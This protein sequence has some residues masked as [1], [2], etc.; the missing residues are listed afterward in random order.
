MRFDVPADD[1]STITGWVTP[2]NPAAEP[3]VIAMLDDGR[4]HRIAASQVWP[5]LRAYGLHA[6]GLCGFVVDAASCPGLRDW[7]GVALFDEH[8][9]T[10]IYRRPTELVSAARLFHLET[11][12][13]AVVA[14]ALG[15]RFQLAYGS[16]EFIGEE[17][18]VGILDIAFT[19]SV[20]VSGALRYRRFERQLRAAGFQCSILLGDPLRTLAATLLRL[21]AQA[22][23][24]PGPE[25][26]RRLGRERL[27]DQFATVDLSDRAS[28]ADGLDRLGVE[29][30]RSLADPV[31]RLL[32]AT[33]PQ[34]A[35]GDSDVGTALE[36]LAAF[37]LIGF[38]EDAETFAA[39]L[40]R[41][42]AD[43]R[44]TDLR[45]DMRDDLAPVVEALA[46]CGPAAGLVALDQD[47]VAAARDAI[48]GANEARA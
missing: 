39:D 28:L 1:G 43:G 12:A 20:F 32:S 14:S 4:R 45:I 40:D 44:S 6:T 29:A 21:Q 13:D 23:D 36:R 31:T 25:R 10:L 7:G 38:E 9:N 47:L 26:W 15:P 37:D 33:D 8:S 34:Q 18:L 30:L 17:T 41:L 46:T 22:R 35:L 42:L 11:G 5:D 2:D 3:A 48:V 16:A 27:V 24:F 19:S